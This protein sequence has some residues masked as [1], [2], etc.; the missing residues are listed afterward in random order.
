VP[1]NVVCNFALK[2][3][4][5][6]ANMELNA[7]IEYFENIVSVILS[8]RGIKAWQTLKAAVLSATTKTPTTPCYIDHCAIKEHH[9]SYSYCPACG[10]KL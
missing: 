1:D 7:A 10:E 2:F 8:Q 4:I 9:Q 6:V 3:I 5:G